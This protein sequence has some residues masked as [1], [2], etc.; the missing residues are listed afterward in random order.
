MPKGRSPRGLNYEDEKNAAHVTSTATV[1]TLRTLRPNST[2][3]ITEEVEHLREVKDIGD[4]LKIIHRVFADQAGVASEF[5]AQMKSNKT[6][7]SATEARQFADLEDGV[8]FK[9]LKTKRLQKDALDVEDSVC[10]L[11]PFKHHYGARSRQEG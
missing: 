8:N 9:E 11:P 3:D 7:W 6:N 4:E 5:V 1:Q 10:S 2:C